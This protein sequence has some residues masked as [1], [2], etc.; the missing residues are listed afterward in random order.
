MVVR[1]SALPGIS[2]AGI[3][4]PGKEVAVDDEIAPF[5][6][7]ISSRLCSYN[8][9]LRFLLLFESSNPFTNCYKHIAKLNQLS[10]VT[11][12]PV[13]WNHDG[14]VGSSSDVRFCGADHSVDVAAGR[15]IDE[16]VM[17]VPQSVRDVDDVGIDKIDRYVGVCMGLPIILQH[18]RRCVEM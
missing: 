17:T 16:R 18:Q 2:D 12:G 8:L 11:D 5:C 7:V 3:N 6:V 15:V 1:P 13:T 14:F 4:Q 10:L 9:I